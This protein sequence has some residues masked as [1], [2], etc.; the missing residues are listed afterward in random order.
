VQKRRRWACNREWPKELEITL[1]VGRRVKFIR[2]KQ[3]KHPMSGDFLGFEYAY[4][5]PDSDARLTVYN[6]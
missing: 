1:P 5:N 4:I 6:D 3:V 2:N